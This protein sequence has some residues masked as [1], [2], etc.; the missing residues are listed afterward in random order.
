MPII[1][2]VFW[3]GPGGSLTVDFK[4]FWVYDID[5]TN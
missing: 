5:S 2:S 1:L 4:G 3:L